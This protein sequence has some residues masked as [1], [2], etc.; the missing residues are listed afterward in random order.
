MFLQAA[1]IIYVF[2]YAAQTDAVLSYLNCVQV[3]DNHVNGECVM[4]VRV[5]VHVQLRCEA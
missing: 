5:H 1:L 2:S 4:H 3:G